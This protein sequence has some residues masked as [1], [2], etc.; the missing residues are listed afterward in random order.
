MKKQVKEYN[1][2]MLFF[3]L[4]MFYRSVSIF[5]SAVSVFEQ[6]VENSAM[7]NT[8]AASYSELSSLFYNPSLF[9][10]T[11]AS[12]VQFNCTL[13]NSQTYRD[14]SVGYVSFK[15]NVGFGFNFFLSD[16]NPAIEYISQN[17]FHVVDK[18]RIHI[19]NG[20]VGYHLLTDLS[21]GFHLKLINNTYNQDSYWTGT[22]DVGH[23]YA[24]DS[25]KHFIFGLTFMNLL[26]FES[27][28]LEK[29]YRE[30]FNVKFG[31]SF[32]YSIN[33]H[34]FLLSF[35]KNSESNFY[36]S[37]GIGGQYVF[38]DTYFVSAGYCGKSDFSMGLGIKILQ[39]KLSYAFE[40]TGTTFNNRFGLNYY[41]MGSHPKTN[42]IKTVLNS[43]I[44]Y[45]YNKTE[46]KSEA[47]KILDVLIEKIIACQDQYDIQIKGY[48][49]NIGGEAFNKK[50]STGRALGVY[51][52]FISK[53]VARES[54]S[55][56]GLGIENPIGDNKSEKG[57]ALNRRVE[58][59]MVI[60]NKVHHHE[61]I[62]E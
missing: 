15:K 59:F 31:I 18:N 24:I 38:K 41:F 17:R 47:F 12:L 49:D 51:E 48:S 62:P 22:L 52:Y 4:F 3:L 5:A 23:S 46:L 30:P 34:R 28:L 21:Q 8:G 60:K 11:K 39:Y 13:N 45:E 32:R 2:A 33:S 42:I 53:G 55:A 20:A 29:T 61:L 54:L 50:L 14:M 9:S 1:S 19:V 25:N 57:R 56:E 58:I 26:S 10:F 40:K 36:R 43:D 44:L 35:D 6:G 27:R 7:G 16:P 37:Y